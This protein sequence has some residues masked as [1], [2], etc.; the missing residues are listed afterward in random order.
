MA[1]EVGSMEEGEVDSRSEVVTILSCVVETVPYITYA[2]QDVPISTQFLVNFT[3][4]ELSSFF[5]LAKW[6]KNWENLQPS[7]HSLAAR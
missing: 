1:V 4:K 2:W 5:S 7:G 6:V 3:D